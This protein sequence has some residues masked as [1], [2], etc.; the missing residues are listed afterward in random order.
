MIKAAVVGA[1]GYIGGELVRLLAMHPEVEITAITSR[2]YAGKKVHKVHPNLRGL[3]LRFTNDYNFD[4]D[5]IFLAVPH[6]TSMKIIEEFL[7][8][9]KI[10]DMSADFRIKKELYEKYYG[11]HEKPELIDRFT[12]GLPEL[13]RK[14]IKKAELVA[15]PGCNATATIL[16][17]YPFKDLTQEA[18]VDLKVSSSAGGRRENIA[19]I[20]P[21]RS[22]V[23]RVYKPYHHRHEAEVLQETRV[24][25]MFTVHSVDLVRGLLATI[26]FRYEGNERELLR[27]LLM[28]KDEPFV[29]IV[30][31]KGG[32]Q[33]YPD[34]KYVIGSNFID[35]GF[36]YDSENSRVM[37]F[38]AIDNLIK[39]GAGQAVQNMNIMFGLK[40]TTGL[41]Y[42]PVYPV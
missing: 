18:I 19:S 9:A 26:Y 30:T 17:L 39:G 16:G 41:E 12:Y 28:Y 13:H 10:I 34:P 6:G 31:D 40:E 37:V 7:G 35:I 3:D 36:A 15:N 4:A 8:S 25:A 42:Y 5:V 14:E 11:P 21:E 20:H 2:Q 27:K 1:S 32:L 29:R 38:S 24:K 22:N 23:V 33:R